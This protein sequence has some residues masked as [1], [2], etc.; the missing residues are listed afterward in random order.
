MEDFVRKS[1][2]IKDVSSFPLALSE[3]L[4]LIMNEAGEI[5]IR[6]QNGFESLPVGSF[7]ASSMDESIF[8]EKATFTNL[9]D[10]DTITT[11]AFIG[12]DGTIIQNAKFAYSDYIKV[13]PNT[14][15]SIPITFSAPG[16]YYDKDK[17]FITCIEN[18]DKSNNNNKTFTTP[19]NAAYVRLNC[20]PE[21]TDMSKGSANFFSLVEGTVANSVPILYGADPKWL[22][23]YSRNLIGKKIVTFGDS[24]TWYDNQP[25]VANSVVPNKR[26][27]GYQTYLRSAFDCGVNN[28]GISGQHSGQIMNRSFTFD[29]STY[30]LALIFMGVNDFGSERQAGEVLPIG[31]D[32]NRYTLV[33]AAQAMIEDILTRSPQTKIGLII[34]YKVWNTDVGGLMPRTFADGLMEVAKLYGIPFL[35]LYDEAQLNELNR[36]YYFVDD[37]T[38]VPYYYHLNNKGYELISRK[39]V[40]FVDTMIG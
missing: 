20:Y 12:N 38:K 13:K 25:F 27:I 30:E 40:H 28:Q 19:A 36:D 21:T 24:I 5:F 6:T 1:K 23:G 33:G 26:C 35:N 18:D 2:G 15:Y 34:P 31:G 29:Y 32:F 37:Q 10:Q 17:Q 22:S 11:G 16:C 7:T 39:I 4:D 3:E 8:Y 14:A 9:F